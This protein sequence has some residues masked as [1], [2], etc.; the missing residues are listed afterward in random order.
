MYKPTMSRPFSAK[1]SSVLSVKVSCRCGR[2]LN[3]RQRRDTDD[4]LTPERLAIFRVL[5][6]VEP[7]GQASSVV[8]ITVS[9]S[10]SLSLR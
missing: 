1:K 4:R 8:R 5:Q 10:P 6:C 9:T 7:G 3:A 2:S